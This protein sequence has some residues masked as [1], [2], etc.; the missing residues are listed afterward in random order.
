MTK[1][2][3]CGSAPRSSDD[4][5]RFFGLVSAAFEQW[6]DGFE[7]QPDNAEH[8]RAWLLCKAGHRNTTMVDTDEPASAVLVVEAAFK[9]AGAYAFVRPY[10]DGLAVYA[11]KSIKFEQADQKKFNPIRDAVSEIIEQ[12]VGVPIDQLLK[13]KAA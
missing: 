2:P 4:H 9:A 8:L 3:H 5:R 1:C 13:E 10:G 6:P 7:F 12:I 11:P